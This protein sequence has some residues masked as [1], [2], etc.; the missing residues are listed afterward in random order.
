M[1][2]LKD[3]YEILDCP[4]AVNDSLSLAFQGLE[5]FWFLTLHVSE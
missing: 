4:L 3:T 2:H 1:Y 5:D